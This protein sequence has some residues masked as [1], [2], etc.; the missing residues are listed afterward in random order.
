MHATR[1]TSL[2]P[3]AR[4]S[5]VRG[6]L[7]VS[8]R[9]PRRGWSLRRFGCWCSVLLWFPLPLPPATAELL[10]H[11]WGV[12]S[13]GFCPRVSCGAHLQE[14]GARVSTNVML[15]DLDFLPQDHPDTRRLEVVADGLPLHHGAQLP[16]TQPW[17]LLSDVMVSPA[18]E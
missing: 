9:E 8:P 17:C 11:R 3:V 15:H 14:A 18:T 1:K 2:D 4:R 16:S 7:H 12:G 6:P 5:H 10:A 13:P